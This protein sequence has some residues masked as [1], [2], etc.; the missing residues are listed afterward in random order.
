[1]KTLIDTIFTIKDILISIENILNQEYDNLLNPN[2]NIDVLELIFKKKTI[3]FEKFFILN[4]N[5][6]SLEKK[7]NMFSPYKNYK[8]L[9]NSWHIILKKCFLLKKLNLKNKILINKNLYLNQYFLELFS[10]YQK[11]VIYDINGNL[12][13]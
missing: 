8:Q 12:K 13:I 7:F 6:L 3:L 4:K 2:T 11:R 9:E 5:R 10:S 1:M